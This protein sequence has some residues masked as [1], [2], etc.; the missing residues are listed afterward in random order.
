VIVDLLGGNRML[1]RRAEERDRLRE[2]LR[3][4]LPYEALEHVEGC[5]QLEP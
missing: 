2:R 1:G 4:G 3:D 5:L